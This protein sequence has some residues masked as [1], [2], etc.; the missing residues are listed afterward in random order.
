MTRDTLV[1]LAAAVTANVIFGL[2][3]PVSKAILD[4]WMTP[5]GYTTLRMFFGTVVFW[6]FATLWR[7]EKVGRKDLI[8]IIIGGLMGYLGTQCSFAKSLEYTSPINFALLISLT[9]VA[10][11]LISALFLH[12]AVT[13]RKLLGIVLSISGAFIVIL[14]GKNNSVGTNNLLGISLA[15]LCVLFYASYMVLTRKIAIRYSPITVAKWMFLVSALS[16]L[17]LVPYEFPR[18]HI[19]FTETTIPAL[20]LLGFAL[21]FSTIIALF[22]VPLA[23][24]K[25][26]P[27]MVSIFMNL[28][29]LVASVVAIAI[30]Q[31]HFSVQKLAAGILVLSGV[32]LVTSKKKAA[33]TGK[34]CS[35]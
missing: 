11:L 5:I 9:P 35:S 25:L 28:Q 14:E 31:D 3:V 8:L 10:T 4:N 15:L 16:L 17:P 12:E 26:E 33:S 27:G 18:Q 7:R 34:K 24:K 13:L 32:Y 30:G 20:A 2:N 23:L 19:L 6:T 22:C 1:G 21:I 29:P